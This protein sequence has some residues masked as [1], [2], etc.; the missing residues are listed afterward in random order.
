MTE[1]NENVAAETQLPEGFKAWNGD[2][3]PSVLIAIGLVNPDAVAIPRDIAEGELVDVVYRDGQQA[4]SVPLATEIDYGAV[5]GAVSKATHPNL[6]FDAFDVEGMDDETVERF[7]EGFP[8]DAY[9]LYWANTGEPIDIV[10]Y[11]KAA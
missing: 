1:V 2:K 4:T 6:V 8:R 7:P 9:R 10:G 3:V 5:E 11:R